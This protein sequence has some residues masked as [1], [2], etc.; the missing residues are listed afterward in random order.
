MKVVNKMILEN[1][2]NAKLD[3]LVNDYAIETLISEKEDLNNY[4][5]NYICDDIDK[6]LNEN[7]L[8]VINQVRQVINQIYHVIEVL[9]NDKKGGV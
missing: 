9:N 6:E 4:I 5:I 7:D 8:K 3:T 2:S 1:V